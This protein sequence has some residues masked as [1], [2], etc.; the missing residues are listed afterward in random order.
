MRTY[1][2]HVIND[3]VQVAIFLSLEFNLEAVLKLYSKN[4]GTK[5]YLL[6]NFENAELIADFI[7]LTN[8]R[9]PAF[10]RRICKEGTDE[11]KALFLL[12]VIE[13]LL[14]VSKT[15]KIRDRFSEYLNVGNGNRK[16]ASQI[17][18]F[19]YEMTKSRLST[20]DM[21]E[22]LSELDIWV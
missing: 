16:T 6:F 7:E 12:S 9:R 11:E 19:N 4:H 22:F 3:A 5:D 17:H 1:E 15:M 2:R 14:L 13:S 10:F 21:T 18:L 20:D 8:S